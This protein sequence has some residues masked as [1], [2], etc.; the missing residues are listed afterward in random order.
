MATSKG[1]NL[2]IVLPD[3]NASQMRILK[4]SGTNGYATYDEV[5]KGLCLTGEPLVDMARLEHD[6]ALSL[7]VLQQHEDDRGGMYPS[8]RRSVAVLDFQLD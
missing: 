5:W 6:N 1:G 3:P 2:Y 8:P 7:L 4:A